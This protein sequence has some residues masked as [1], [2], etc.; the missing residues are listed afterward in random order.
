MLEPHQVQ[1]SVVTRSNFMSFGKTMLVVHKK[2]RLLLANPLRK[3]VDHPSL[4]NKYCT[5]Y[6]TPGTHGHSK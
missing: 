4:A 6:T 3:S 2:F 5:F 1:A